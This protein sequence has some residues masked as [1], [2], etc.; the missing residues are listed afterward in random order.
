MHSGE[1]SAL[2]APYYGFVEGQEDQRHSSR[3]PRS[4]DFEVL[5]QGPVAKPS[6]QEGA[7]PSGRSVVARRAEVVGSGETDEA[8]LMRSSKQPPVAFSSIL[9][10]LEFLQNIIALSRKQAGLLLEVGEPPTL[11]PDF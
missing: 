6:R 5:V 1:M 7:R 4:S 11:L 9:H 2:D 8:Y 10:Y 3:S